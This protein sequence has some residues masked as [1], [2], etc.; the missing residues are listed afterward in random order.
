MD[1]CLY[2]NQE[3]FSWKLVDEDNQYD[4]ELLGNWRRASERKELFCIECSEHVF[5][6]AGVINE[7][8]FAHYVGS[9]CTHNTCESQESLRGKRLLI[10][11]AERS[12]PESIIETKYRMP[13]GNYSTLFIRTETGIS[14]DFHF[15]ELQNINYDERSKYYI[16]N[17]I[18]FLHVFSGCFNNKARFV[19]I[20]HKHTIQH[21][22]GF[23][24]FLNMYKE[25]NTISI[26]FEMSE[27][28]PVNK[29]YEKYILD[30][31]ISTYRFNNEGK[32]FY[33]PLNSTIQELI[34]KFIDNRLTEYS[35]LVSEEE[36]KKADQIAKAQKAAEE[37]RAVKEKEEAEKKTREEDFKHRLEEQ[38]RIEQIIREKRAEDEKKKQLENQREEIKREQESIK[39][40]KEFYEGMLNKHLFRV[41]NRANNS[42]DD[43]YY[44]KPVEESWSLPPLLTR[45]EG[46]CNKP[47]IRDTYMKELTTWL[48][49]ANQN[50]KDQLIQY[51]TDRIEKLRFGDEWNID[52]CRKDFMHMKGCKS[53]VDY[54]KFLCR[55]SYD[56]GWCQFIKCVSPAGVCIKIKKNC[57]YCHY[58]L[59]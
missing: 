47:N 50:Q 11:M 34:D 55:F 31:H 49:R 59:I 20:A 27:K 25:N 12:F 24:V 14:V 23:C 16:E 4:K 32:L 3:I 19:G 10:K 42:S 17:N 52:D 5:L 26:E 7:P 58:N 43:V 41:P 57:E 44:I 21:L 13:D 39:Q 33:E 45:E 30:D 48:F 46:I 56:D 9:A 37:A 53:C 29:N 35:A 2:N 36:R 54:N 1:T 18:P 6:K 38:S 8:H 28:H 40:H 15:Y 22:Q 51:A